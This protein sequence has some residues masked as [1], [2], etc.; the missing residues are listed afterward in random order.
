MT[1]SPSEAPYI[2]GPG[3]DYD[4]PPLDALRDPAIH[5]RTHATGRAACIAAIEA[6]TGNRKT[7]RGWTRETTEGDAP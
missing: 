5:D 3:P 6:A 4:P 1:D 7:A 2:Q